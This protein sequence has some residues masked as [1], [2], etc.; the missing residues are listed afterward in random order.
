MPLH[1]TL[2]DFL[3][4]RRSLLGVE[5]GWVTEDEFYELKSYPVI[6]DHAHLKSVDIHSLD[7][8]VASAD[9]EQL[10]LLK[11]AIHTFK[12]RRM[13]A[14]GPVLG[15]L[16]MP[17]SGLL[18]R[19]PA[20]VLCPVP[21]HWTRRFFRGFNQAEILANVVSYETGWDTNTLLLVR[22]R[23]TGHQ[24]WRGREERFKAVNG[25][26][27]AYGNVPESVVLID[28]LFTTGATLDACAKVLKAAGAKQV[29]ALV[30]A[31]G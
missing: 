16:L 23:P 24:A 26:F 15:Q 2:L 17:A 25:A 8:V 11:R 28:D 20:P 29:Q 14:M 12:Y 27:I 13:R 4:P 18:Q 5:G 22:N 31:R 21:L 3:F 30:V 7:R 19:E 10:P 1:Q 6:L 9:Y